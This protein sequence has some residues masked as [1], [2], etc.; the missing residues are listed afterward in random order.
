MAKSKRRGRITAALI[1]LAVCIAGYFAYKEFS[2]YNLLLN[3]DVVKEGV[4]LR[5]A[6]P[7]IGDI[8]RIHEEYRLGTIFSVYGTEDDDVREYAK[9]QGI[10]T[11]VI[12]IPPGGVPGKEQVELW[13]DLMQGKKIKRKKYEDIIKDW[14]DEEL[15]KIRFPFPIL[16]HCRAGSDRAG[17]MVA[18]YRMKFDNWTAE[19]AR[20]EMLD[21]GHHPLF[22]PAP[23]DF[24][25]KYP[26]LTD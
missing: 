22:N 1:L 21:H 9:D 26:E 23:F 6:Q 18:L 11:L 7:R 2:P 4:L 16:V 3:F 20:Q 19:Q 25:D 8:K 10:K 15:K 5:S 13:F 14:P 12:S 24:I 17:L